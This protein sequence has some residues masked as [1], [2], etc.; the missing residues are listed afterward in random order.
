MGKKTSVV[1]EIA[2]MVPDGV[3]KSWEHRVSDEHRQT[4]EEIKAAYH[5]G[6]F[7]ARKS[8]AAR[9]ISAWLRAHNISH[10]GYQG[11]LQWLAK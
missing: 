1:A 7:G 8:T 11:V 10:V 5:A 2:A 4:L 3:P 6:Q 9:A